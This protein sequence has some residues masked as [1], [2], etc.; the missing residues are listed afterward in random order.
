MPMSADVAAIL[1]E[2][3]AEV[4]SRLAAACRRSGRAT[5]EVEI[6][7]VTKTVSSEVASIAFDLGLTDFGES[8]PQELWKKAAAI[9]QARW[10]LVGH[11][12]RNKL[13]RTVPLTARS[14]P[15]IVR[16]CLR[17][18]MPSAASAVRRSRFCWK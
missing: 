11:L 5:E 14:I 2:R 12:Q 18:S 7:G 4:R 3:I 17:R 13:D 9:P 1:G 16:G 15:S 8:K 6:V 10:H